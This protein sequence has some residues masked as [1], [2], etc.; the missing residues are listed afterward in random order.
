MVTGEGYT[1]DPADIAP[2]MALKEWMF[3]MV[4][5]LHQVLGFQSYYRSFIPNFACSARLL[6]NRLAPSKSEQQDP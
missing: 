6:Y 5:D 1:I 3:A 2:V 4:G